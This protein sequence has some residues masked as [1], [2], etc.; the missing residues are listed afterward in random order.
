MKFV[1]LYE[2]KNR[3][4]ELVAMVERGEEVAITRR[5]VPVARLVACEDEEAVDPHQRTDA[6][7]SRLRVLRE[8][9]RLDG[10]LKTL[11]REGLDE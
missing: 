5:G 3:L 7:L 2:A 1:A 6:A 11:A 10:D 8:E 9:I 4:S